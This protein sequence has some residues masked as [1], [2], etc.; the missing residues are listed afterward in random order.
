[1][2]LGHTTGDITNHYSV[3]ELGELIE[4]ANRVCAGQSV[5]T[6]ALTLIKQKAAR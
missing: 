1:M 2:L 3:P 4:A 6:P 5:K